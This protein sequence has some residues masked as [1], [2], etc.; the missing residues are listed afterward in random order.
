MGRFHLES[1]SAAMVLPYYALHEIPTRQLFN[2]EGA[3]KL[4]KYVRLLCCFTK[5][6]K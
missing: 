6:V 2:A 4:W 1:A 5:R 3:I